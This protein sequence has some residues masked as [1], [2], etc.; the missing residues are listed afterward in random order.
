MKTLIRRHTK[1]LLAAL[2]AAALLMAGCSRPEGSHFITDDAYRAQVQADFNAKLGLVGAQFYQTDS[3][4]MSVEEEEALRFLYAYMPVADM[5]DYST[6]FYLQNVRAALR[7]VE[8]MPWGRSVPELYF[9]HFVLPVR[10]NNERLDTF[11]PT[12]YEELKQRVSGLS[13]QDAILEV[14]HWC[15]EHVTYQPSDGRTSSP[16]ATMRT[17]YG[18]CGE[19][20]T[21]TVSALRAI[22]IPARQVYTPRWAHTDDNHAWVEAWADGRWYFMGACEPEAVLNLGWFNSAASR[23]LLMHTRVF[24]R[25][26]GPEEKMLESDT[27]TEINLIDNY[28]KTARIDFH[29]LKADGTPAA[30]ARIDFMIY[31]YAE[32]NPVVTKYADAEGNSFLTAGRGDMIVWASLDGDYGW[33]K[34]SFGTDSTLTITLGR[35]AATDTAQQLFAADSL[36]IVPPAEDYTLPPV[37]DEQTAA[38]NARKAAED[39]I[40]QAYMDTFLSLERADS[41]TRAEG[42]PENATGFLTKACGNWQT[43]LQF[44]L[45]NRADWAENTRGSGDLFGLL[46]SLSDKDLRD[47]SMEVLDDNYNDR[48]GTVLAPRVESE[49]LW[50]YKHY[51]RSHIPA[52]LAESFRRDPETLVRWCQDSLTLV[53]GPYSERVVMSA[54]GVW[55]SRVADARSR[56]VFFV[57]VLRSLGTDSRRDPVTGKVQYMQQGTWHDVDFDAARQTTAPTGTLVM[58]YKPLPGLDNPQYYTH[59]TLSR[60][61]GGTTQLLNFSAMQV[62]M[63]GGVGWKGIFSH[64]VTLDEGTYLLVTGRRMAS[65]KVLA[66]TQV[67]NIRAGQTT[68]LQLPMRN[69]TDD[70]AV[71]GSFNSES[72]FTLLPDGHEVSI[73]SQTGRGYF[74]V[75]ILG[76]GQEPTNHVLRDIAAMHSQFEQWGRKMILLFTD[77]AQAR[78]FQAA[79]YGTLPQNIIYGIDTDG[80]VRSQIADGMDV[81]DG[82]GQLPLF[83]I[84]DTFNRVV[85]FSQGYTIGIG[86]QMM[87]CI[88]RL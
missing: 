23:A 68:R 69:V 85:F 79:D 64:G 28:A 81:P 48:E 19:E 16:M 47:V 52:S 53:S 61:S 27:F 6:A 38:N 44:I 5:T 54:R 51:L 82:R 46:A 88:S 35:N 43:I 7:T 22:G 26:D 67:L 62:D 66:A 56:A 36:D 34:A 57:S 21:F 30:G 10:V 8:E 86:G 40:R 83:V 17:A 15:H 37:T 59:F 13:M 14:N 49:E 77:E 50:P 1:T 63:G 70:V 75:G 65:G 11:R 45:K 33:T 41:L 24:G 42:L 32:F 73:L 76:V 39:S 55:Q 31:N 20:S 78:R 60:I 25:Y 4:D 84:A 18:R 72:R 58:D 80:S 12:Y 71:I 3:L 87:Q 2:A 29:I 74:A 9:R